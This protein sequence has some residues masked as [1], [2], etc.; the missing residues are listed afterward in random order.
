MEAAGVT[1]G[2]KAEASA[3]QARVDQI[4][5]ERPDLMVML[6]GMEKPMRLDEFMAA[7][8]AEADE[9]KADAPLLEVAAQC[10]ILNG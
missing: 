9:M 10:A 1:P 7:V 8:K 2:A 5:A 6:D 4:Q 3:A